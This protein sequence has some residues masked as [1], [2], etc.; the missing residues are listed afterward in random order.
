MTSGPGK[1]DLEGD[2]EYIEAG[3]VIAAFRGGRLSF[4]HALRRMEDDFG[5]SQENALPLL[6]PPMEEWEE[7]PP[8][9]REIDR[10]PAKITILYTEEE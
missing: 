9:E 10:T 6:W 7:Q 5:V 1:I 3:D 4:N 2:G 8:V